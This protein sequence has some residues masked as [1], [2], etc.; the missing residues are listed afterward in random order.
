MT[1]HEAM[2]QPSARYRDRAMK[3]MAGNRKKFIAPYVEGIYAPLVC[4]P[5]TQVQAFV[6]PSD[7]SNLVSTAR[8]MKKIRDEE[9]GPDAG[10]I[11]RNLERNISTLPQPAGT[12][13]RSL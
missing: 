12:Q 2:T 4:D 11:Q 3:M 10:N 8:V 6:E 9:R 1:C 13:T 7:L 5:R